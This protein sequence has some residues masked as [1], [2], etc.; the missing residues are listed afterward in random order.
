M[1]D[2]I[3]YV[4]TQIHA[5]PSDDLNIIRKKDLAQSI[6]AVFK[7]PVLVVEITNLAGVFNN[8]V[9]TLSADGGLTVD[10]VVLALGN[11]VLLTGQT[12]QAQN[13]I[14]TITTLGVA[15]T[16]PTV[17]TRAE[18]FDDNSEIYPNLKVGVIRG[19]VYADTTWQLITDNP[20]ISSDLEFVQETYSKESSNSK[21]F[22]ITA[23]DTNG[24][25]FS[26]EF[27]HNFN[28]YDVTVTVIDDSTR[29]DVVF[30]VTRNSDKV[31]TVSVA[32]PLTVAGKAFTVIVQKN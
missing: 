19:L 28:T 1:P 18:D 20:T 7:K 31:I 27:T 15:D 16:S 6:S 23:S 22:H 17:L 8:G 25:A 21:V 29:Q 4:Q 5:A 32:E 11:R 3:Q 26:W 24:T 14:Y 12:N 10:G 13:G 30:G 9:L 2:K